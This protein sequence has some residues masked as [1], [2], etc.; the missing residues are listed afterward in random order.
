MKNIVLAIVAMLDMAFLGKAYSE[1][2]KSDKAETLLFDTKAATFDGIKFKSSGDRVIR[3]LSF[4]NQDARDA[5]LKVY[6]QY[7]QPPVK[8]AIYSLQMPGVDG[9]RLHINNY[10]GEFAQVEVSSNKVKTSEGLNVDSTYDSFVK[11][12]GLPKIKEYPH[13]VVLHTFTMP[14]NPFLFIST[15]TTSGPVKSFRIAYDLRNG[16]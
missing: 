9:V 16:P 15:T 8:R 12:Y 4:E 5:A 7:M 11:T 2:P 13:N 10:S 1:N 6:H 14:N 3:A